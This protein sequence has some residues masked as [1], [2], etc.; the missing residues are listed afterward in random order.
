MAIKQPGRVNRRR[1]I[2]AGGLAG[3]AP[4]AAAQQPAGR[5]PLL[6][7]SGASPLAQTL[8]AGLQDRY[9]VRLTERIPVR[10]AQEFVECALGPDAATNAAVRGAQAIVH[11]AEPLPQD[12]PEQQIDLL[13]RCTYNLLMAAAAEAVPR[14]VLLSTLDVMSGYPAHFTVSETW[15]PRPSLQPRTLAKHLG[16]LTSREF[17]REGKTSIVVLRLGKVV[18]AGEVQGQPADP[19]WVEERDVIHAV[20]SA[21]AARIAAWQIFHILADSPR[22]RFAVTRAKSALGYQPRFQW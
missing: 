3:A 20:S 10:A 17:A 15:R 5:K 21:L 4:M 7:T 18:R 11:V 14:V 8:A 22:A 1:F 9:A 6:I 19:L 13:T 16:E 2:Q 12:T